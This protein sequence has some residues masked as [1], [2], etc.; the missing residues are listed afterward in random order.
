MA[1]KMLKEDER[2]QN[3]LINLGKAGS[4]KFYDELGWLYLDY[5]KTEKPGP[6]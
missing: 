4:A 5:G 6:F 1:D 3:L 2:Y